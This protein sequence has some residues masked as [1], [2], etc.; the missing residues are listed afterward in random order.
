M[1]LDLA[2]GKYILLIDSDDAIDSRLLERAVDEMSSN[3][4]DCFVY[5][6]RMITEKQT[7]YDCGNRTERIAF[8]NT[9][10]ALQIVLKGYPFRM[11]A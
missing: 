2:K 10:E 3:Q 8:Y 5:G 6:Y 9:V 4:I 11:L 7:E 1:G